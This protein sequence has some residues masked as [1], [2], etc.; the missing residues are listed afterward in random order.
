[1]QIAVMR[2]M[3]NIF[4]CR[5]GVHK[6]DLDEYHVTQLRDTIFLSLDWYVG[7]YLVRSRLNHVTNIR[8]SII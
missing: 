8:V 1:M 3:R 2:R 6:E 5:A 7:L 4:K